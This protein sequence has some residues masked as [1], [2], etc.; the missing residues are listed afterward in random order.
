MIQSPMNLSPIISY[1]A[2]ENSWDS[3]KV[4]SVGCASGEEPYTVKIIWEDALQENKVDLGIE[5]IATDINRVVLGRAFDGEVFQVEFF[6]SSREKF[7]KKYFYEEGGTLQDKGRDKRGDKLCGA[8]CEKRG[9]PGK[10]SCYPVQK[11][12]FLRILTSSCRWKYWQS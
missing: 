6:G 3:I 2:S 12:C 9:S 1:K 4:W 7:F 11:P 10:V 8:G 5:I